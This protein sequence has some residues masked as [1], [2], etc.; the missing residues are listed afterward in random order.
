MNSAT[1]RYERSRYPSGNEAS[2]AV[3]P[4]T[5]AVYGVGPPYSASLMA[6]YSAALKNATSD[7]PTASVRRRARN[8]LRAANRPITIPAGTNL[9]PSHGNSPSRAKQPNAARRETRLSRWTASSA[10]ATSSSAAVSSGY[11]AV[12]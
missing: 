8:R 12:E 3:S 2:V 1:S 9:V 11:T 6:T 10:A 7:E 5:S 4:A